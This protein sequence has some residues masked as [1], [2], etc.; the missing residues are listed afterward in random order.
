MQLLLLSYYK[1]LS[2]G[3][4]FWLGEMSIIVTHC[5]AIYISRI[6]AVVIDHNYG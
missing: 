2:A 6:V 1:L 5:I 4:E 3:H